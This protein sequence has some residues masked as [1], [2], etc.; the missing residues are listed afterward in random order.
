MF[1]DHKISWKGF[2]DIALLLYTTMRV[3]GKIHSSEL[4]ERE[5]CNYWKVEN[6]S[7][8]E[9]G[10]SFKSIFN[11][12]VIHDCTGLS[13][14]PERKSSRWRFFRSS[15]CIVHKV[16]REISITLRFWS[17]YFLTLCRKVNATQYRS[18]VNSITNV[19]GARILHLGVGSSN[20]SNL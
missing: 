1:F 17:N 13:I 5:F 20:L 14:F 9:I 6:T 7:G 3:W 19:D 18:E 4:A 12:L 2:R 8:W 10:K 11:R 16:C 15:V